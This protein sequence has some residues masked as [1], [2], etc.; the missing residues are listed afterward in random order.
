MKRQL[1]I[2]LAGAL[3]VVPFALTAYVIWWAGVKLDGLGAA[4]L[5]EPVQF[6]GVGAVLVIVVIYLTGL[7]THLWVF[8]GLLGWTERMVVRV[9]GVKT[10]YE[11][12][13]DLMKLFGGDSGRMG[14]TVLY[15]D[16]A[17]GM[18]VLGILTNESPAGLEQ[19][20][21]GGK[22]AVY[23]PYSYMFG[24]PTIYVSRECVQEIDMPV[25]TALKLCTTAQVG[26]EP[27]V[28]SGADLESTK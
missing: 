21:A 4:V 25:E 2:M 24:G 18:T 7:L 6:P 27:A 15:T 3:V 1:R 16:P 8:R 11:S 9:P 19:G 28:P 14:R 12:V 20:P 10:I 5:P 22:V 23:L 13:R 26:S 17:G